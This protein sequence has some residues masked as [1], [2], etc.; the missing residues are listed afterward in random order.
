[1]FLTFSLLL[2][3]R[4]IWSASSRIRSTAGCSSGTARRTKASIA[5][6]LGSVVGEVQAVFKGRNHGKDRNDREEL[7]SKTHG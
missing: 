2:D 7:I 5:A 3:L 4:A 1:M 6:G